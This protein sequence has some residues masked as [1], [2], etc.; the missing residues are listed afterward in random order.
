M[1]SQHWF[2][3]RKRGGLTI[4]YISSS[5]T[6][7]KDQRS[8][9]GEKPKSIPCK[10][11]LLDLISKEFRISLCG[12]FAESPQNEEFLLTTGRTHSFKVSQILYLQ[13]SQT[14]QFPTAKTNQ[15]LLTCNN[16]S[17]ISVA[18]SGMFI[19]PFPY[20]SLLST[21]SNKN[22]SL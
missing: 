20:D 6:A 4:M 21:C 18:S 11:G 3:G 7:A 16:Q 17:F 14:L 10:K 1:Y 2:V 8:G 9:I 13:T 19:F 22:I 15:S 5:K 12:T